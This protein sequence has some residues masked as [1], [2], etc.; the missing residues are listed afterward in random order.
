MP[1]VRVLLFAGALLVTPA[2]GAVERDAF[3]VCADPNN[4]PFSH[5]DGTGFENRIAE[6][7]ARA[8]DLPLEYTW[9]PQR[10]G[11]LRNTL[12]APAQ[13]PSG[14]RCD[15]VMGVVED[16]EGVITT[17]AYYRSTY[18]LVYARG[19]SLDDV[20][21][22]AAFLALPLERRQS[23][24]IGAFVPTPGAL[25][26]ARHGMTRSIVAYPALSGDPAAY[27]GQVIERDLIDGKLD[28][29][30]IWGPIA[31][32]FAR[33]IAGAELVL[34]PLASEPGIQFEFAISAGVRYGEAETRRELDTLIERTQGQITQLLR[35]FNVPTL[36]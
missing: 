8:L 25:W 4:L 26:L 3:R 24:R 34:L 30:L 32:Y 6:L 15:V 14:F 20:E 21:S 31:G 29:V 28:A 16:M 17:R 27:P 33:H 18:V 36:D 10:R 7:W 12:T 22:G 5:R 35:E 23:L 19:R 11:F 1:L 13:T 2:A 9:F